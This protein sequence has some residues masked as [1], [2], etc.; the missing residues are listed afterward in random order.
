MGISRARSISKERTF[1]LGNDADWKAV[2]GN[3]KRKNRVVQLTPPHPLLTARVRLAPLRRCTAMYIFNKGIVVKLWRFYGR[4]RVLGEDTL[5]LAG[6]GS[7]ELIDH[8]QAVN[9]EP[10]RGRHQEPAR[11]GM[12]RRR[13]EHVRGIA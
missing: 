3:P 6:G 9:A 2:S 11:C 8:S 13:L 12:R 1:D 4:G 7:T 10:R 5:L